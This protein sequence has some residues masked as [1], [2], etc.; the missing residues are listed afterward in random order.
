MKPNNTQ[1]SFDKTKFSYNSKKK[2]AL[3]EFNNTNLRDTLNVFSFNS[4]NGEKINNAINIK[5]GEK[6]EYEFPSIK[7]MQKELI[8][9]IFTKESGEIIS[10]I[11]QINQDMKAYPNPNKTDS[12]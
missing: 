8:Q 7:S 9:K 5:L 6:D 11:K 2:H 10:V 3:S 4:N 12:K 1:S